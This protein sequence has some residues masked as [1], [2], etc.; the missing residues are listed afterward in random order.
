MYAAKQAGR[1]RHHLFDPENDRRARARREEIGRIR[2]GLANGEFALHYQPKVN[3]RQGIVI[4][5]EALIRWNHPELGLLL[6]GQFLHAIEG[7]ELAIEVGDWVIRQALNQLDAWISQGLDLSVS[8][9]IAGNHLQHAGFAQRLGELL[10]AHPRVPPGHLELE[11]LETAVLEDIALVAELFTECR[12]LGVS[13]ALDDFGTGYSSLTYFRRLPADML[14]I[15]QSFVRDML[16]D[17]EDLAIVEGVIGLTQAF[18]RQVIAEGVE[19]AEHGLVLL[20]LGCDLAQGYGIARPMPADLLPDWIKNFRPDELWSSVTT[21]NW[22]RED[23]PLL[24]AETDHLRWANTILAYVDDQTG[25]LPT[26][27]SS[28]RQCRFGHWFYGAKS[29]QYAHLNGFADIEKNHCR[30][31]E[32]GN[33]LIQLHQTGETL[34]LE[35]HKNAFKIASNALREC[36][37]L[38][39]TEIL[40]TKQAPRR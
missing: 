31:H 7:G 24:I 27:E 21:F 6:P 5:A 29:Q 2:H 19:T 25:T 20:L 12:Q 18:K 39:Q 35:Q 23:L 15:D 14:K 30:L 36:L 37:Q 11:I 10:A 38:I 3:M 8:I 26:P 9:N 40:I 4:G 22:S 34:R 32:I 17:P 33:E 28:H 13:F 16:D 1:N